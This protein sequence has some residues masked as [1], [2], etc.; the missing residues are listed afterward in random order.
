MVLDLESAAKSLKAFYGDGSLT[1]RIAQLQSGLRHVSAEGIG[2]FLRGESINGSVLDSAFVLKQAAGQI[3]VVVH[4]IGILIS[5][6]HILEPGETVSY[7]SLGAGNTGKKFDLETDRR[8]AEFKFTNWQGG[9]E[10]IRQNQI[11]KDLFY[12]AEFRDEKRRC[13]YVTGARYPLKFLNGSRAL[14]SVLSRNEALRDAFHAT[15]GDRYKVVSDYYR[16]VKSKV[17][18]VDLRSVV[19]CFSESDPE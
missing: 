9:A 11:F 15:Y 12:L 4:A 14:T 19:P 10:S 2:E 6:P 16:D 3:N 17:E 8:V 7:A 1:N 18:I 13:L 5:L